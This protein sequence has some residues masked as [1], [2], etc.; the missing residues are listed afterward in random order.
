MTETQGPA[1]RRTLFETLSGVV[2]AAD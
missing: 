2:N 1:R